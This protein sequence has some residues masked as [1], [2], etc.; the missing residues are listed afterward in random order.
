MAV[1]INSRIL[2]MSATKMPALADIPSPFTDMMKPPSRPPSCSGMKNSMLANSDV[3]A[4]I[5]MHW[6]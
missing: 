6:I 3:N 4:N 5:R 2:T 1:H